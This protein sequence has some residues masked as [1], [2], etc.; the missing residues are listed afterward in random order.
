MEWSKPKVSVILPVYNVSKYLDRC[1]TSLRNQTLSDIEIICVDDGSNDDSLEI[2]KKYADID[3]RFKVI[4]QSNQGQG[5]ARNS[6]IEQAAGNYIAFV[7]P[8]D[9]VNEGMYEILYNKAIQENCDIVQCNYQ[10]I[11]PSFTKIISLKDDYKI[12]KI[13]GTWKDLINKSFSDLCLYSVNKIYKSDLIKKYNL[14]FAPLRIS[15]EHQFVIPAMLKANKIYNVPNVLYYYEI[16]E[17]SS[18]SLYSVE[19]LNAKGVINGVKAIL[20]DL[21]LF[22]GYTTYFYNYA[23]FVFYWALMKVSK[24]KINELISMAREILPEKIYKKVIK[25]ACN[26][27]FY[28]NT[29]FPNNVFSI[30]TKHNGQIKEKI[31]TICG[32]KYRFLAAKRKTH[33]QGNKMKKLSI[34][35]ICYNEPALELTCESIVKQTWQNFEWIVIDGGSKQE[36][37]KKFDK[38][39]YRIDKF[40]SE[41]DDGIYNAVNKGLSFATGEYVHLL[42]AGD[43]YF[44]ENVLKNVFSKTKN[45]DVV[46][47]NT[48]Y[49]N[50]KGTFI[51]YLFFPEKV[52]K[53]LFAYSPEIINNID[54]PAIFAKKSLYEKCGYFNENYKIVSDKE[55]WIQFQRAGVHFKHVNVIITA[56]DKSGISSSPKTQMLHNKEH[57]DM[58]NRYYTDEEQDKAYNIS[59]KIKKIGFWKRLYSVKRTGCYICL[60]ILFLKIKILDKN[61][62]IKWLEHE[63]KHLQFNKKITEE[64]QEV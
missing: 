54:T 43:E 2:C 18:N 48:C 14:K 44:D 15:E 19:R 49:I 64:R 41:P 12:K 59:N 24:N 10:I 58:I 39:K 35:T 17:K 6:G 50:H 8:D 62:K 13:S 25:K 7:D 52:D 32:W 9:W 29:H 60:R 63:L 3:R 4:H 42:N 16:R 38:Y 55:K 31:L 5:V 45:A 57:T 23:G 61:L 20:T 46:Y 51:D 34:I 40:I 53:Y 47:G 28:T 11:K 27:R 36:I 33:K 22:D 30:K 37:L 56:F 26:D 1:L 21:N